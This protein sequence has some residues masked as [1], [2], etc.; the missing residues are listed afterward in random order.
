MSEEKKTEKKTE[1]K[2]PKVMETEG[3]VTFQREELFQG[4]GDWNQKLMALVFHRF[5]G[6]LLACFFFAATIV[7]YTALFAFSLERDSVYRTTG[8]QVRFDYER[9][10]FS[11]TGYD[12]VLKRREFHDKRETLAESVRKERERELELQEFQLKRM[13]YEKQ[14]LRLSKLPDAPGDDILG[15]LGKGP[16]GH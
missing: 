4:F 3:N 13:E 1:K 8:N 2:K 14:K 12:V 7:H 10:L 9:H 6:K 15:V 11:F 5:S 16:G